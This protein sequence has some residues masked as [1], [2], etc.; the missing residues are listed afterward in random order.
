[1][2]EMGRMITFFAW[3]G[4][5]FSPPNCYLPSSWDYRHLP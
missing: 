4:F 3:A 1:L 2:V 5:D